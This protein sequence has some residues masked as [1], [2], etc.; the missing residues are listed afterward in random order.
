MK[1]FD[2]L[3]RITTVS[4]DTSKHI[5]GAVYCSWI[6]LLISGFAGKT[7]G[8]ISGILFILSFVGWEFYWMKKKNKAFSVKDVLVAVMV[9]LPLLFMLLRIK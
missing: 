9:M 8:I 4:K 7:A 5:V 6:V 3:N 2:V 1:I